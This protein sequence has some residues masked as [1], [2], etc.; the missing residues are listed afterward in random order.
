MQTNYS[1]RDIVMQVDVPV[2]GVATPTTT[3]LVQ[4]LQWFSCPENGTGPQQQM[5][6]DADAV[7]K[8]VFLAQ[9]SSW[10]SSSKG[11]AKEYASL[12]SHNELAGVLFRSLDAECCVYELIREGRPCKLYFD[13]EWES[14]SMVAADAHRVLTNFVYKLF[15]FLQERFQ[16]TPRLVVLEGS[17]AK[18]TTT[19]YSYHVC[20][21]NV[22][23]ASNSRSMKSAVEDFASQHDSDPLFFCDSKRIIDLC[24]YTKNR[25]FRTPL[26]HKRN[27][28]TRTRLQRIAG[29]DWE[30][31]P[32]ISTGELL[33]ALVTYIPDD[34][35]ILPDPVVATLPQRRCVSSTAPSKVTKSLLKNQEVA[36]MQELLDKKGVKGFKVIEANRHENGRTIYHCRNDSDRQC[37]SNRSETH[38]SNNPYL[39][40]EPD[41]TVLHFCHASTCKDLE[42]YKIGVLKDVVEGLDCGRDS[43]DAICKESPCK[44]AEEA[45]HDQERVVTH[46]VRNLALL[47]PESEAGAAERTVNLVLEVCKKSVLGKE[48]AESVL[49]ALRGWI[50]RCAGRLPGAVFAA[51]FA[52]LD[53]FDCADK[54]CGENDPEHRA[55]VVSA[56]CELWAR[57]EQNC[58]LHFKEKRIWS[59]A[60]SLK[61]CSS[62]L[63]N[64][65][66]C[67]MDAMCLVQ[68][69]KLLWPDAK[70]QLGKFLK[71]N[72][73]EDASRG[74]R[75]HKLF[76][77]KWEET[78]QHE[79]FRRDLDQHIEVTLWAHPFVRETIPAVLD[80]KCNVLSY[81]KRE[82]ELVFKLDT[83]PH[84]FDTKEEEEEF[85]LDYAT[86]EI[87]SSTGRGVLCALYD[88]VRDLIREEGS[89]ISMSRLAA[90]RG[91]GNLVKFDAD[92]NSWRILDA[93]SGIWRLP[94]TECEP[95][96]LLSGFASRI[97]KPVENLSNFLGKGFNLVT[98]RFEEDNDDDNCDVVADDSASI[99]TVNSSR[100]RKRGTMTPGESSLRK[101]AAA[102][103]KYVE[104]LKHQT[105]VLRAAQHLLIGRFSDG[106]PHLLPC[107]NGIV[108]LRTGELRETRPEDLVTRVCQTEY[109]PA[110]N[111]GPARSFYESFLP[112]EAYTDQQKLVTFLSTWMGYSISG[113]TNLEMCVYFYGVGSNSK[114]T[115]VKLN[116]QV[117][118][119]GICQ[120]VPMECLCKKKG[121]NNDALH[122][123][124][125]ARLVM[126]SESD[127]SL[128]IHESAFR[129]L[130]SGEKTKSKTMYKRET[131]VVPRMKISM[132]VNNVPKF[133]NSSAFCTARR[134][135]FF[136][137][138]KIFV[139]EKLEADRREAEHYRS[140][141]MPE[142]LIGEKDRLFFEK[143]VVGHETSFLK[144]WVDGAIQYYANGQDMDIPMSLQEQMGRELFDTESAVDEFV[145]EKLEVFRDAKVSVKDLYRQFELMF[146]G[147][148]DVVTFDLNR[149]G[150]ELKK[151]IEARA[152]SGWGVVKKR[153]GC[154]GGVKGMVWV[155]L[156][157]KTRRKL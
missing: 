118:G 77:K 120:I 12:L 23:F 109:D 127:D 56:C 25:C 97:F 27:D 47:G 29:H 45:A 18:G 124:M 69:V 40:L 106:K 115:Q 13:L 21:C 26:S 129:S 108:N 73:T 57:R 67:T 121:E 137:L 66:P 103:Y 9:D 46:V 150:T 98:G 110:A 74:L 61:G 32:F 42:P 128:K 130:I 87:A 70:E 123:A 53:K 156:A 104:S 90:K 64:I 131:D 76:D 126:I 122:D 147:Q 60:S 139:D 71:H 8:S 24:V 144:F 52:R 155:N 152:S 43:P 145:D 35:I 80:L 19:K 7:G 101:L 89:T 85:V 75:D 54:A 11:G 95:H 92:E 149:F 55:F 112:L 136:P 146:P 143:H 72:Y 20:V 34:I 49:L 33:D 4:R 94:V 117:L 100:K 96:A 6:E 17:R 79:I 51:A 116:M 153:N 132:Y 84:S 154:A 36:L 3:S 44:G 16:S 113:E 141:K 59:A 38:T 31:Q 37:L 10:S 50:T 138:R 81:N 151:R 148:V 86:G 28:A 111:V 119:E 133:A 39:Q 82:E 68:I 58:V 63:K 1:C 134:N 5:F 62:L 142:S 83:A 2:G 91:F 22:A 107:I 14:S 65:D 48:R 125:R 157:L 93:D 15:S 135:A 140:M 99:C 88:Y 30:P 102:T 78:D 41:G 105:D 114:S